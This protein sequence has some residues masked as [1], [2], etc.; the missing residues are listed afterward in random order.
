MDLVFIRIGFILIL[1]VAAYFFHPAGFNPWVAGIGGAAAA[2]LMI[3]FD[4][5]C[6]RS[7]SSA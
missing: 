4:S 1:S 7:A 2:A 5:G 6:G 3:V